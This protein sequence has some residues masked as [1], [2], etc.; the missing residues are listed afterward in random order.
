MLRGAALHHAS[1]TLEGSA[2]LTLLGRNSLPLRFRIDLED[3]FAMLDDASE[4]MIRRWVAM[5][6]RQ[7]Q[8]DGR[9]DTGEGSAAVRRA[10]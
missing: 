7:S 6:L 10:G 3:G 1:V 8:S 4:V 5:I 2:V 9:L